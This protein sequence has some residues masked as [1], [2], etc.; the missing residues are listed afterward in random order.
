MA[1]TFKEEKILQDAR[2]LYCAEQNKDLRSLIARKIEDLRSYDVLNMDRA[3]A[4]CHWG[5]SGSFLA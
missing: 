3:V 5:R 1:A 4:V 2:A